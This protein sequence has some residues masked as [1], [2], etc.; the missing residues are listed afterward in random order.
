[1]RLQRRS[2]LALLPLAPPAFA[3]APYPNRPIRMIIPVG[4]GGA[5]DIVGRI[6]AEQMGTILG[7]P[8]IPEN[9]VGAGSTIGAAAFQR[10]AADGYTI[11]IATNN[12]PVMK[13][14]YRDFPFDPITDFVPICLAAR[15]PS[16]LVVHPSVPAQDVPQLLAWLRQQRDAANYGSTFPGATNYVAGAL[17]RHLAGLEFT[18]VPYR[19]A[20]LAVQD[21]VAGRVQF[22]I[23][24]PMMLAPLMR[25]GRLR[26]LAVSGTER[27]E[28]MPGLPTIAESGVAGYELT[29]WQALFVRP[30]TPPDAQAALTDAARRAVADPGVR[31]RLLL[32]ASEVWPDSSPEAAAAH[33]R[34]QVARWAPMVA[35]MGLAN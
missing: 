20:A 34:E 3:Q 1:M 16:V 21:L 23:D 2:L 26:G 5:T 22:T 31:A 35:Q 28:I 14:I 27:S 4:V 12:H 13:A 19:T 7:R 15:Q 33:V 11:F 6:L 25:E 8:V 10:T 24:S 17:F 18:T 29:A 9:V 32:N 30:G